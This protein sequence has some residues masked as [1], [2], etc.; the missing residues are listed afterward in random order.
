MI[1]VNNENGTRMG[2]YSEKN[3]IIAPFFWFQ[4]TQKALIPVRLKWRNPIRKEA[5]ALFLKLYHQSNNFTIRYGTIYSWN[6]CRFC[7]Q[8]FSRSHATN[9]FS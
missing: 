5:S 8:W 1:K 7:G 3:L 9:T 2:Q 6:R 4:S